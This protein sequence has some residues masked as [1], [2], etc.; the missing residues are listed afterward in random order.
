M[1]PPPPYTRADHMRGWEEDVKGE[2]S[3]HHRSIYLRGYVISI[4]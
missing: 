4:F 2:S 3:K 1:D